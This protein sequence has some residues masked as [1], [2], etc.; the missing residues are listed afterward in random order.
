MTTAAKKND[1]VCLITLGCDKNLVDAEKMTALLYDNGYSLTDNPDE[2][3][4][5]VVNTCCFISDAM[6]ESINTI[7]DLGRYR[8][9]GSARALI[10]TGCLAERYGE[11]FKDELP[12]VDGVIGTNAYHT[13]CSVIKSALSGKK[14]TIILPQT[15]LPK[16]KRRAISTGGHYAYLKI[17]EGCDKRCTYCIIPSIRG[18]YRS[19]PMEDVISEAKA[20][21]DDGV[22]ELILV[23]Q[24]TTLYGLDI[25]DRRMLPELL[26]ELS[27]IEDIKW[28]RLLYAYPEE[29]TDEL[30]DEIKRNPKVCHYLDMPLQHINDDILSRMGRRTTKSEI[31]KRIK[32]IREAIPDICL[33]TTVMTGFPGETDEAFDEL[34]EFLSEIRFERV[35]SFVF[36]P[37]EGT[38][39]A[40]FDGQVD[41]AVAKKHMEDIMLLQRDIS[42]SNNEALIGKTLKVFVE[43]YLSEDDVWVGRTYRDAPDVD[44]YVFFSCPFEPKSGDFVNVSVTDISEYDIIGEYDESA[45]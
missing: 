7:I 44:G 19:V 8:T 1:T 33:R 26:H 10:V 12:E 30:I 34:I 6:E 43:G 23:A 32:K 35:G 2:A 40:G 18:P 24:E 45:Q 17:A 25:Y 42:L 29:I 27:L 41:E 21:A 22:K 37:Q 4:C 5:I 20:L 31:T 36:S 16:L 38:K 14:E 39:A 15:G 28:I 11:A 9:D 13:L 3:D